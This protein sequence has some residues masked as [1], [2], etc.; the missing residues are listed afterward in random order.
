MNKDL[1]SNF[2]EDEK[3]KISLK[4]FAQPEEIAKSI[5]FLVSE[6]ASYING[7]VIQVDGG[8]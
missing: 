3:S 8:M 7:A 2:I 4:R 1:P 5:L 6:D